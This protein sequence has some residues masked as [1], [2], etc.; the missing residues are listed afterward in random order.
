MKRFHFTLQPVLEQRERI[1]DEKQQNVAQK[2]RAHDE[3]DAELRRLYVEF[4]AQ[5]TRIREKHRSVEAEELRLMYA[6][7]HFL[8]R[9]IVAQ[10]QIVAEKKVALEKARKELLE[11]S[12]ERKVVE[13]LKE[14]RKTAHAAEIAR[15]E[16]NELDDNNARRYARATVGGSQ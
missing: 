3:A 8:D 10:I 4:K 2:Q 7:V 16:Q 14:R 13:K 5:S 9:C 6:H 1:E 11:A 15:L 12:K